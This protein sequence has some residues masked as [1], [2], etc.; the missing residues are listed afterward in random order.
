MKKAI[1]INGGLGRVLAALPAVLRA[2]REEED[3]LV[4]VEGW[5]EAYRG[6]PIN[7]IEGGSIMLRHMIDG[8]TG[9]ILCPEPYHLA[10]VRN[11]EMN[12]VEAFDL[13][14]NGDV[15]HHTPVRVTPQSFAALYVQSLGVPMDRP[16]AVI[17]PVGSGGV[18]DS[19]S[20]TV[21]QIQDTVNLLNES[22]FSVVVLGDVPVLDWAGI[23]EFAVQ[24][25]NLHYMDALRLVAGC[26]L[27]VGCDSMGIHAAV[28]HG[29]PAIAVLGGTAGSKLYPDHPDVLEVRPPTGDRRDQ[30][31]LLRIGS[32][33]DSVNIRQAMVKPIDYALPIEDMQV[34]MLQHSTC[35][36]LQPV[37]KSCCSK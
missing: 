13:L 30:R 8:V 21:T 14:I 1:I 18:V 23:R 36:K 22:G 16:I 26:Q 31:Q 19:R 27:F 4:I 28:A 12:L 5:S 37:A 20:M 15:K 11:G 6:Q 33:G 9:D 10:A 29:V 25:G 2:A 17:Q 35:H 3:T 32:A 7:A 24:P 34:F